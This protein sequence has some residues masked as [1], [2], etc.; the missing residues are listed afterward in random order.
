MEGRDELACCIVSVN[1]WRE[2]F[3]FLYVWHHVVPIPSESPETQCRIESVPILRCS[4]LMDEI[5]YGNP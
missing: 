3:V 4:V 2:P 5:V 1:W